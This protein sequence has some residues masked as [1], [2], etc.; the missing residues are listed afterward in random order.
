MVQRLLFFIGGCLLVNSIAKASEV[1]I[2]SGVYSGRNLYVQNPIL[3]DNR[4][5]TE[6]V[7]VNEELV[8]SHPMT[9]AFTIDLSHLRI[10][11]K[12]EVRIVHKEGFRPKIINGHVLQDKLIST[13][14]GHAPGENIFRWINVDGDFVRWLTHGEKGGGR[15]E[16]QKAHKETWVSVVEVPA[17]ADASESIY[18]APII[19]GNSE[20]TYRIKLTDRD[21]YVT[22]SD[23]I[24]YNLK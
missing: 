16:V 12:I 24:Q 9:S 6:K 15:F 18:K 5:S 19:H 21:G 14:S 10:N 4:F 3:P 22:Y 1:L 11:E 7:F 20:N 17:K 8:L 13:T 2:I 23:L